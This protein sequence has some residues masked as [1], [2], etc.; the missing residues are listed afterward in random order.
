MFEET[1][2]NRGL[3]TGPGEMLRLSLLIVF[4]FVMLLAGCTRGLLGQDPSTEN[5]HILLILVDDMDYGDFSSYSSESKIPTP[6]ID[7]LADPLAATGGTRD[8][9]NS[10]SSEGSTVPAGQLYNLEIDRA[11]TNNVW[12][13]HPEIVERLTA[14]LEQ[15]DRTGRTRP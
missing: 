6:R 7:L 13:E 2:L 14:L 5:S 4:A 3:R 15:M 8:D 1:T 10:E 11:E 12:N 9:S